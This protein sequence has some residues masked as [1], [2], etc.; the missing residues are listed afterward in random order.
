MT[1][2]NQ[3]RD[4]IL[5]IF[6]SAKSDLETLNQ[7]IQSQIEEN[8]RAISKLQVENE[9]LMALK[10]SNESSIKTFTKFFR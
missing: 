4:A 3:R 6:N 10:S 2:F 9:E 7:D 8:Q 5:D 1:N